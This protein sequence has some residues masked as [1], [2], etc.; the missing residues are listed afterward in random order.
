MSMKSYLKLISFF[1]ALFV[2]SISAMAQD[3]VT[4]YFLSNYGFDSDFDYTAD[5]KAVVKEEIRDIKGV[6]SR[7]GCNIYNYRCVRVRIWRYVQRCHSAFC[8]L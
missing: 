5:S 4:K 3:D 1:L 2:T 6:D 7:P 8:R